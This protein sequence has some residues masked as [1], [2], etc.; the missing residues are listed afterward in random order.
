LLSKKNT[1]LSI[2]NQECKQRFSIRKLSVG[3][4]SVLLG[5]FFLNANTAQ[6]AENTEAAEQPVA[7]V[8]ENKGASVVEGNE[9]VADSV[10]GQ[11]SVATAAGEQK[12]VKATAD[13]NSKGKASTQEAKEANAKENSSKDATTTPKKDENGVKIIGTNEDDQKDN[14]FGTIEDDQFLKDHDINLQGNDLY[15]QLVTLFHIFA[16]EASLNADTNGNL[17]VKDL[18]KGNDFG[19][20]GTSKN[21]TEGDIYYI[22]QL[23]DRLISNAFRNSTFNH[24]VFGKGVKIETKDQNGQD[25]VIINDGQQITHLKPGDV[26]TEGDSN[27]IDFDKVFDQLIADAQS[28]AK[29]NEDSDG[30]T[31]KINQNKLQVDVSKAVSQAT[32]ENNVIYANIDYKYLNVAEPIY[33]YGLSEDAQGP[34]VIFNVTGMP[35]DGNATIGTQIELHYGDDNK[36]VNIGESHDEPNHVLWNFGNF[37]N[38]DNFGNKAANINISSG[39]FMGSILAPNA[40]VNVGVNTDGNIIA[41][42]V[43]ITGGESHRWDL[44]THPRFPFFPPSYVEKNPN[45][46][47][48]N[49]PEETPENP[50]DETPGDKNPGDKTPVDKTPNKPKETPEKPQTPDKPRT[51]EKETPNTPDKPST[52]TPTPNTPENPGIQTPIHVPNRPD[53]P[54]P[55]GQTP[56]TPDVPEN[57]DS[58]DHAETPDTPKASTA[59]VKVQDKVQAVRTQKAATV[60]SAHKVQTAASLPQTSADSHSVMAG[61]ALAISS[62]LMIWGLVKPKK[63]N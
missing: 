8:V 63:E 1:K 49:P 60:A 33:V 57:S 3:V 37:D 29:H 20:R 25:A 6:A 43:N 36:K 62:Q 42:V 52:P 34:T 9:D 24:V 21:L 41:K 55:K 53:A 27:Y 59:A 13:N 30:V 35:K 16:K 44:H 51:P 19:T 45:T 31:Q 12:T 46:P 10:K 54:A 5:L 26:V 14:Y 40:T 28:Y 58:V 23:E 47:K 7:E 61:I 38:F 56:E 32:P 2:Q 4:A 22:Q 11:Q 17:A 50:G 15:K 48:G 18:K 39:H